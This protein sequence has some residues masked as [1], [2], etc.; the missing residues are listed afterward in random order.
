MR[1][2]NS[3]FRHTTV[4]YH[5]HFFDSHA[6]GDGVLNLKNVLLINLTLIVHRR[7]HRETKLWI[8]IL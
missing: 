8:K 7:I 3:F 1:K 6:Y 5:S 4:F 2:N